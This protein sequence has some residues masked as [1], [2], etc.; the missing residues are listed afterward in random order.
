MKLIGLTGGIAT[1]KSTVSAELARRGAAVVDSDVLAREV[2]RRGSAGFDEVVAAFGPAILDSRGDLDRGALASL[3]FADETARASLERI[4]HPRIRALSAER[5]AA[6][7]AAGAPLVVVDIPLL[8]EHRLQHGFDGTLLVYARDTTQLRR[9][10]SR[11]GLDEVQARRRLAAQ[12]PIDQ[13]RQL[14]TWVIDNDGSRDSTRE[15]VR[16]WWDEVVA[17]SS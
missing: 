16:R 2:V 8:F 7:L 5:T 9:L 10:R 4:T 12:M 13:K 17:G 11:D 15:Q 6:A 3:V 14:A 1:G